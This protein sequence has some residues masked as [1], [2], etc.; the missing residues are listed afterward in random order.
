MTD[1]ERLTALESLIEELRTSGDLQINAAAGILMAV[2]GALA[3]GDASGLL[4]HTCLYAKM[5]LERIA[6]S[7]AASKVSPYVV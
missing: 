7:S 3:M 6:A 2:R 1:T 4:D 5:I